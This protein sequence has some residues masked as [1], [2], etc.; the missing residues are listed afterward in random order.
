MN[1][2]KKVTDP[3]SIK[4]R[5]IPSIS[6]ANPAGVIWAADVLL[7]DG[8]WSEYGIG[9]GGDRRMLSTSADSS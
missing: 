9:V 1:P 8:D 4:A 3:H 7:V 5:D 6:E 2:I